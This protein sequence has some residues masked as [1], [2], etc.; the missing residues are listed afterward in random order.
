MTEI[1]SKETGFF[2]FVLFVTGTYI[3]HQ[4]IYFI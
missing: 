1:L 3:S 2:L 4:T